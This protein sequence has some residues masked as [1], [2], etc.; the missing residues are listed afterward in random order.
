MYMF[1][2]IHT[3]VCVRVFRHVC[4]SKLL[5]FNKLYPLI[6]N[7]YFPTFFIKY[8]IDFCWF[9]SL[10]QSNQNQYNTNFTYDLYIQLHLLINL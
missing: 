3:Y 4:V 8:T 9:S 5:S 2:Y 1:I 6:C 10:G 7:R